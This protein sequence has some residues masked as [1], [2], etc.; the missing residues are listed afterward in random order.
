M[1]S[2]LPLLVVSLSLSLTVAIPTQA[3]PAPMRKAQ[4]A[5]PEVELRGPLRQAPVG[6]PSAITNQA[7][8]QGV[9][10]AWGIADPPRVNFLTYFLFVHTAG[11]GYG[12]LGFALN[13]DGDLRATGG[14]D[15]GL[16]DLDRLASGPRYFIKSFR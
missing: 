9:A 11:V 6:A 7:D 12:R 3:A 16:D 1:L 15:Q 4:P 8:W 13:G 2:R 10:K 14:R 5:Q